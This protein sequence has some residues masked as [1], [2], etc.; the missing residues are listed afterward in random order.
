MTEEEN[1]Q[2]T[3]VTEEAAVAEKAEAGAPIRKGIKMLLCGFEASG[4]STV[5]SDLEDTLVINFDQKDYGFKTPHVNLKSYTSMAD[6]IEWIG[7]SLFKYK[8]HTGKMPKNIV[9]DT[10]TQ[11]YTLMQNRNDEVYTGF[12]SHRNNGKETAELNKFI[13][14]RLI[15]SGINVIV[16]A[17]TIWDEPTK[18]HVIPATGAFAKSGSWLSI[19]NDSVFLLKH[20]GSITVHLRSLKY[21]ART[22]LTDLPDSVRVEKYSLQQH[23]DALVNTKTAADAFCLD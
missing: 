17:H 11:L 3:G 10:V 22:T 12:E 20:N 18:R 19:V 4:K 16:V 13:E 23:I 9:L 2:D 8:E 1:T 6:V 7:Q 15:P 14:T 5:T 21:P